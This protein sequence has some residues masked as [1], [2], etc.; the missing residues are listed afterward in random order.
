[1]VMVSIRM[2]QDVVEALKEN[3]PRKG[4]RGHQALLKAYVGEGLRRDGLADLSV[5]DVVD[6]LAF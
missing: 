6:A 2:P 3:A 1:M 5:A 4:L